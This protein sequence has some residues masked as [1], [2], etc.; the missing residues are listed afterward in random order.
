VTY[1]TVNAQNHLVTKSNE[2][3]TANSV[4]QALVGYPLSYTA[5]GTT[6][7]IVTPECESF[8][9]LA[10]ST[11]P[12]EIKPVGEIQY[13]YI[14][15]VLQE[16]VTKITIT[17]YNTPTTTKT[18]EVTTANNNLEISDAV[19]TTKFTWTAECETGYILK[20]KSG[21]QAVSK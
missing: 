1:R 9:S 16:H 12:L 7:V 5:L 11:I 21:T 10:E 13:G 19:L 18:V 20:S 3:Y 2:L 4:I 15:P 8:A 14:R 6:G 17:Y